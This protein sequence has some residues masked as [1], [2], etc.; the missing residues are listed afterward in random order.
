MA[1]RSESIQGLAVFKED[2]FLTF[3]YDQLGAVVE[4]FN[5][6]LPDKGIVVAF[7]FDYAEKSRFFG[8]HIF[9]ISHIQALSTIKLLS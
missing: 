1:S 2:R 7:V 6:V 8:F 5:R 4:I 9:R 3:V